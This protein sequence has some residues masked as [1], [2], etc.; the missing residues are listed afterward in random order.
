[1][2]R[3]N[4][5]FPFCIFEIGFGFGLTFFSFLQDFKEING[6]SPLAYFAVDER[7]PQSDE[8]DSVS[9]ILPVDQ[10]I[11]YQEMWRKIFSVVSLTPSRAIVNI[12][13]SITLHFIYDSVSSVIQKSD[14]A[15]QV[16][17]W[18]LD[19]FSPS[20]NSE[21]WSEDLTLF[22]AKHSRSGTTLSTY[23]SAGAVFRV[24][25]QAGFIVE[26]VKGFG[27]KR[28]MLKGIYP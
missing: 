15:E 7:L 20:K 4:A 27:K 14:F 24:L 28:T 26:K 18:F 10:Q 3:C 8:L 16:D 9:K 13:D 22:M 2:Q 6:S 21:M 25:S 17:A 5:G 19:G 1:M 12:T 23:S 11:A